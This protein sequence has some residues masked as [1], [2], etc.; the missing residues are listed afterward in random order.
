MTEPLALLTVPADVRALHSATPELL[1]ILPL[2][3]HNG[4]H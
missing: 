4:V 1:S 3:G 2:R